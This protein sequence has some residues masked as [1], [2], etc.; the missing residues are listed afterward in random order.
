MEDEAD[1]LAAEDG[2]VI[3][4]Q[5]GKRLT[6]D[7]NVT[8]IR[9]VYPTDHVQ[10]RAFATAAFTEDGNE[11]PPFKSRAGPSKHFTLLVALL[12]LLPEVI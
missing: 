8:L 3:L 4:I 11:F 9:L 7:V 1:L 2:A 5:L 10:Q 6:V 12:E